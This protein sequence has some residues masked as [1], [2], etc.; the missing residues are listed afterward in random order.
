MSNE[1]WP[2]D[3]AALKAIY[4]RELTAHGLSPEQADALA[5]SLLIAQAAYAGGRMFYL[6]KAER[7]SQHQRDA[8]IYAAFN[9]HNHIALAKRYNLTV[10]RIY[11]I[12]KQQQQLTQR[13]IQPQLI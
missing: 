10:Q 13:D 9:G 3:V 6:P 5:Q 8:E 12:I 11:T 4:S 2:H 1:R 7:L